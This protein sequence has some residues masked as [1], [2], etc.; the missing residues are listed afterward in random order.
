MKHI[1]TLLVDDEPAARARLS[2]LLAQDPEIELIG[3]CRNGVEAV[4]AIG[5]HKPDLVF[6]DVEMPQ[7]RSEEHTS[8]L[9]SQ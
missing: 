4:E 9:Q 1:R 2:R 6:L 5:K 3:E 7:V 8:E